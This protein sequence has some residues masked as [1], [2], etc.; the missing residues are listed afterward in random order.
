[1]GMSQLHN[2]TKASGLTMA[3][4]PNSIG[5]GVAIMKD[6]VTVEY[7]QSVAIKP[8]PIS[9]NKVIEKIREKVA[10]Y[11]PDTI[12]FESHQRSSKS[13][14]IKELLKSIEELCQKKNI[15]CFNY[16][17]KDI[18]FVFSNFNAHSKYE[19]AKTITTN[20]EFMKGK[21]IEKRRCYQGE[22]HLAGA[23]DAVSLGITHFYMND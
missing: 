21:L 4:F 11:E 22:S 9:N 10:Y 13:N 6:A 15:K 12:V 20:V 23:F 5:F 3:L 7:A 8:R 14:R 2:K 1:M 19:I 17:R 18:R 16:S